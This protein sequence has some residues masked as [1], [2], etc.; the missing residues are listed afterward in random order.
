[1]FRKKK[2]AKLRIKL[3]SFE[4]CACLKRTLHA[5]TVAHW[6]RRLLN[7]ATHGLW[8]FFLAK[9]H[10]RKKTDCYFHFDCDQNWKRELRGFIIITICVFFVS[11]FV[12]FSEFRLFKY[13]DTPEIWREGYPRTEPQCC[14]PWNRLFI[15]KQGGRTQNYVNAIF[16][17]LFSISFFFLSRSSLS[18]FCQWKFVIGQCSGPKNWL[19]VEF[20]L[21]IRSKKETIYSY[22]WAER[23][24][25]TVRDDLKTMANGKYC[26]NWGP[27]T[28][29]GKWRTNPM[30]WGIMNVD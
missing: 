18:Y 4:H 3:Y 27:C 19:T 9:D 28:H 2:R 16:E 20:E 25:R 8:F 11:F 5:H 26:R 21:R 23:H 7:L 10:P 6:P 24:A 1:M 14:L 17:C 22:D 13:I 12:F 15:R 30:Y 29:L